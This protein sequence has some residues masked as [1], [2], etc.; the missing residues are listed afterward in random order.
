VV[1]DAYEGLDLQKPHAEN[2]FLDDLRINPVPPHV[3]DVIASTDRGE[4][5]LLALF[6]CLR[7]LET[8][9]TWRVADIFWRYD[10]D[11]YAANRHNED[12]SQ[13]VVDAI[14]NHQSGAS[15]PVFFCA[16]YDGHGGE[17]AVDFV[18]KNLYNNIRQHIAAGGET[19]AHAII[20][21]RC[22][23]HAVLSHVSS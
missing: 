6:A 22:A 21:V 11:S 12:R 20:S 16:C 8:A 10:M 1:V 7:A 15:T 3:S 9:D 4:A 14:T 13:Y 19:V 23:S 2:D 5:M 18:Q 17:E